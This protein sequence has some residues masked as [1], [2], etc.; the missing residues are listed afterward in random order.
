MAQTDK[1]KLKQLVKMVKILSQRVQYLSHFI[2]K[3]KSLDVSLKDKITEIENT[4]E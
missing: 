3:D 2:K 1:V 4:I